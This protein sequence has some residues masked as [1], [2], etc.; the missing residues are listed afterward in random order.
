M[1]IIF[2]AAMT[3]NGKIAHASDELV[4]W[5]S[6]EDKRFFN[7]ET[8]KC[9]VMIMGGATY[10]TI[11]R[12]LPGRLNVV[13]T[14]TPDASKNQDG[15]LEFT[16]ASPA[17]LVENLKNRGFEQIAVTGGAKI[18]AQF[19]EAHLCDELAITIEP[20]I[21]GSGVNLFA[22]MA[23]DFALELIETKNL[24]PHVV[25]LRYRMVR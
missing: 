21:F 11:G 4:D 3:V 19:M 12:P 8:K 17:A 10:R 6:K 25:L 22:D 16:D 9:G 5:T 20:K 23:R 7:E 2:F 13:M 1:K 24:N 18:F 15:L 14:R